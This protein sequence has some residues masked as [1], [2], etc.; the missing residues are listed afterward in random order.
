MRA[1]PLGDRLRCAATLAPLLLAP[2]LS[3][4]AFAQ[5]PVPA[6]DTARRD[7]PTA[8]CI[9]AGALVVLG[10]MLLAAPPT[11]LL[12]KTNPDSTV[13]SDP[14]T[15]RFWDSHVSTYLTGGYTQRVSK[16][17]YP[18]GLTHSVGVEVFKDRLTERSLTRRDPSR[19][20]W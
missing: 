9:P 1:G 13:P 18:T 5:Q 10:G 15:L 14:R 12:F 2:P 11:L 8:R 17:Q 7:A 19:A 3:R 6:K 16:E 4:S 20:C